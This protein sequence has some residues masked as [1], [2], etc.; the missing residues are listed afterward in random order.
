MRIAGAQK[1]FFLVTI[2]LSVASGGPA[3]SQ[4]FEKFDKQVSK[5]ISAIPR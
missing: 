3:C 2:R 1:I 5:M 4:T